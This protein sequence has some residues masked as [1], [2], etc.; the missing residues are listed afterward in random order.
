M[1]TV[2][3]WINVK[4]VIK[5]LLYIDNNLYRIRATKHVLYIMKIY[6]DFKFDPS[7]KTFKTYCTGNWICHVQKLLHFFIQFSLE[8]FVLRLTIFI[9]LLYPQSF[10]PL[11]FLP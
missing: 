1:D 8:N 11:M 4:D 5:L 9:P 3:F 7:E 10:L 6:V 2:K